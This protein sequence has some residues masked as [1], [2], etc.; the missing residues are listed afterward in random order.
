MRKAKKWRLEAERK[1]YRQQ[2]G[3]TQNQSGIW[4]G[5]DDAF[6]TSSDEGGT[7]RLIVQKKRK[8]MCGSTGEDRRSPRP[9]SVARREEER[10]WKDKVGTVEFGDWPARMKI[11][12]ASDEKRFECRTFRRKSQII[13]DER[14]SKRIEG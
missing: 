8:T 12:P 4:L 9:T 3:R 2:D 10:C 13:A 11:W 5:G 6:T 14:E 7:C 1:T